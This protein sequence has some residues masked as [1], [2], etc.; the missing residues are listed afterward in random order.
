MRQ[1]ETVTHAELIMRRTDGSMFTAHV[2][3]A[4]IL[5]HGRIVAGVM[6]FNDISEQKHADERIREQAA[7]LHAAT[8]AILAQDLEG[9]ATF[10][11]HSASALYGWEE[12][13]ALYQN[14]DHLLF[15]ESGR[16]WPEEIRKK[17]LE[18]NE[19][20]GELRQLTKDG[21]E[22]VVESRCTL[23]RDDAGNP[24]SILVINTDI[25][26]RKQLEAQLLRMQRTESIGSLASGIAHDL[27][28]ALAPILMALHTLQQ[29][30]T[31]P[32]SQHWL[33]LIRKSA[34]RSR[35][36][37]DQ[38]LTFARGA[39]G[40]R[41]PLEMDNIIGET[42]KMLRDTLPKNITLDV[43]MTDDLW[44]LIGDKTQINQVLMNLCI[45]ARDAMP[46]GGK[47]SITGE[48]IILKEDR[49]WSHDSVKPGPFICVKIADTG[50]GIPP[51]VINRIFDPFFTTKEQGKGTG[52][53]LST[54]IGIIK[55]HGGFIEV[56]STPGR[57][58]EFR[59][60]LPADEE[61]VAELGNIE[62]LP[63]PPIQ[64]EK[65][66][67]VLAVD[68]EP[69]L[70]EVTRATLETAGYR[71][72]AVGNGQEA[73]SYYRQHHDDIKLVLTDLAMPG[74]DG[75]AAS[76]AMRNINPDVKIIAT[77][78]LRS[79]ANVEDANRVG[80][81]AVLWKPYSA[82]DLLS[83]IAEVIQPNGRNGT[84]PA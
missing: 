80:V 70:L 3:A 50:S 8:D 5:R 13:E 64:E 84:P 18:K 48:N 30:F 73:L 17:L 72:V 26:Q 79:Q 59:V 68:D 75:L 42:S 37:V 62:P 41:L 51:E 57:G 45:N 61:V 16:R 58:S 55:G 11:N 82:E 60:F 52:L 33:Q 12:S 76:I 78:G 9:T 15:P 2:E 22:I 36:L 54:S 23:V 81:Q 77:S 4:P 6:A 34:E 35:D 14:V 71:V 10:W 63:L 83:K 1:G 74:L 43:R 27:N 66:D 7:L 38:V 25:T 40:A 19:W 32:N 46:Q 65:G 31:D 29:K 53:G 21:R 47:L 67:L 44:P 49:I 20:S 56:D 69:T 28:N 39:T 24:K